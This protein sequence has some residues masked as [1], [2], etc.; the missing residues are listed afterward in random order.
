MPG[1]SRI[2]ANHEAYE[3]T[4]MK[5]DLLGRVTEVVTAHFIPQHQALA[6]WVGGMSVLYFA[7]AMEWGKPCIRC[8]S[9]HRDVYAFKQRRTCRCV[10]IDEPIWAGV[11]IGGSVF[12]DVCIG[13]PVC[14]DVY[15][16]ESVRAVSRCKDV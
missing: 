5:A 15:I 6:I 2:K 14:I 1:S 8:R 3:W 10:Y 12:A 9:V 7:V 4:R 13:K 16:G 11:Y